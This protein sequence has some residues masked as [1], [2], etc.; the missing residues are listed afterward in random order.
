MTLISWFLEEKGKSI[1][2]T[3]AV[4]HVFSAQNNFYAKVACYLL[5]LLGG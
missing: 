1:L 3:P 4:F 2:L 5:G